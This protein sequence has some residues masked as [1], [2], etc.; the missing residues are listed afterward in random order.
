MGKQKLLYRVSDL[1]CTQRTNAIMIELSKKILRDVQDILSIK[2]NNKAEYFE[3]L[4][5][6]VI[7]KWK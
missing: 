4:E 5:D 3:G 6:V 1:D 2:Y 7:P